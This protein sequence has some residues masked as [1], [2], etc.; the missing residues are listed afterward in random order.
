M[1]DTE[2]QSQLR[3]IYNPEG[4]KLRTFQYELLDVL[5]AFDQFCRENGLEYSLHAGT[6]LG[7]IRHNG[8]IPWDDDADLMVTRATYE[9]I[10]R[11]KGSDNRVG[12]HLYLWNN[13]SAIPV[14]SIGGIF[15]DLMVVDSIPTNCILRIL[16]KRVSQVLVLLIKARNAI[17][18]KRY[19]EVHKK[20]WSLLIP[21]AMLFP[22][23]KLQHWLQ[24]VV[25]TWGNA[26][27]SQNC[28]IYT[29]M[30]RDIG[31]KIPNNVFDEYI[32]VSF[33]GHQLRSVKDFDTHLQIYYADYM[34]IPCNKIIHGR[35]K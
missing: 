11:R 26:H 32:D 7:A 34:T 10:K 17:R 27:Q 1:F 29:D 31:R 8:F 14:I 5:V 22:L 3:E 30:V 23:K 13:V 6:L 28:G 33:E 15:V 12:E 16:K 20:P 24:D 21:V 2:I 9:Q 35:V 19:K 4:S 18:L 25:A